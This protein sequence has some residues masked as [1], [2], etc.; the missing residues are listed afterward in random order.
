M[1]SP[2][3]VLLPF[4][5]LWVASSSRI[6]QIVI[7]GDSITDTGNG[8]FVIS[9]HTFPSNAYWHG[10]FSNG[11]TYIEVVASTLHVPLTSL[12]VGGATTDNA[13]VPGTISDLNNSTAIVFNI[14]SVKDQV[15]TY[16][17]RTRPQPDDTLFTIWVGNNDADYNTA[18]GWNRTGAD[19]VTVVPPPLD[20]PFLTEYNTQLRKLAVA[21]HGTHGPRVN[22]GLFDVS[23]V[24]ADVAATPA[25]FGFA[26]TFEDPCCTHNCGS[27]LPPQGNATICAN[28]D[29][30]T[31]FDNEYH[32]TAA[33][34]RLIAVRP[35]HFIQKWFV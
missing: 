5:A 27:G 24:L 30:Y 21:F 31:T 18:L 19:I 34:H 17:S 8:A 23:A 20:Q 33:F 26:H 7:F 16:L 14:P 15:A 28:P 1:R 35:I 13:K 3:L 25:A 6:R 22:L 32:P 2:R 12:A 11:P 9:N 10:R 29:A 4:V